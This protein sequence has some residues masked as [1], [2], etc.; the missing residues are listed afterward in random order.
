MLWPARPEWR[1]KDY[2]DRDSGRFARTDRR[3]SHNPWTK[4]E[5]A[6]AR[7]SRTNRNLVAGNAAVGKIDDSQNRR[8]LRKF[9]YLPSAHKRGS[10]GFTTRGKSRLMGR[11][12]FRRTTAAACGCNG[13]S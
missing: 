2:D 12:A 4:L 9:L 7:A 10:G 5:I 13:S 1:R 8:S 6:R 3:R 11:E